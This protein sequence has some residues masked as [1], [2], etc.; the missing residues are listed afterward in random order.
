MSAAAMRKPPR[1]TA[2][3]R[4]GPEGASK[5]KFCKFATFGGT[6]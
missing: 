5:N 3:R 2:A 1:N 4:L 6:P